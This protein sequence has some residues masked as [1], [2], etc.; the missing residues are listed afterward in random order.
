[1]H[2]IT[3]QF[4]ACLLVTAWAGYSMLTAEDLLRA[5]RALVSSDAVYDPAHP[6]LAIAPEAVPRHLVSTGLWYMA[7]AQ[8]QTSPGA[9]AS[10]KT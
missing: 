3:K 10:K 2:Q 9:G 7:A 8:G 1:M 5:S 6:G 4:S